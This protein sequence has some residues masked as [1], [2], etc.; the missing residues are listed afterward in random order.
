MTTWS[1]TMKCIINN[2]ISLVRPY[3]PVHFGKLGD[4]SRVPF[5]RTIIGGRRIF[6]G[7][8]LSIGEGA[9]IHAIETYAGTGFTPEIV[10]G[11]DV[12]IGPKCYIAAAQRISIEDGCVL[13]EGVYVS[14]VA[15][16]MDPEMGLIMKQQLIVKGRVS[17]GANCF[18]GLRA[19]IMPGVELGH[20]CIVGAGSVVTRS[21]P[22]FSVLVGNPARLVKRYD[23]QTRKWARIAEDGIRV[24]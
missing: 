23:P 1:W 16:G 5:P 6:I 10:I 15:H 7:D 3:L 9:Y 12:Y 8:R 22:A 14:D 21:Y 24:K 4:R 19:A 13:S 17:I 20:N 2:A 11:N 18:I